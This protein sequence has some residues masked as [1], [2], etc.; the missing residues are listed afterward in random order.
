MCSIHCSLKYFI[1]CLI[2]TAIRLEPW[3]KN[4]TGHEK[5]KK[6]AMRKRVHKALK[7]MMKGDS[8]TESSNT[9]SEDSDARHLLA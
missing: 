1:G 6:R 8:D 5:Q 3:G 7:E 9:S 2:A 4:R